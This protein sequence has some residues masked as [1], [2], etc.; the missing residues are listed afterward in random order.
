MKD[1]RQLLH[2]VCRWLDGGICLH[3]KVHNA[4]EILQMLLWFISSIEATSHV[5]HK[6]RSILSRKITILKPLQTSMKSGLWCKWRLFVWLNSYMLCVLPLCKGG[7]R[8][9]TKM[10][11]W[12]FEIAELCGFRTHRVVDKYY[13]IA[14]VPYTRVTNEAKNEQFWKSPS[15]TQKMGNV[16]K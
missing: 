9:N 3:I 16:L 7:W 1:D 12:S 14:Q 8:K 10:S 11:P 4:A 6:T 13:A 5:R 15:S 2:Q